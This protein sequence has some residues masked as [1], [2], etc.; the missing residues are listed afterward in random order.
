[1]LNAVLGQKRKHFRL[2]VGPIVMLSLPVEVISH[3]LDAVV[4]DRERKVTILPGEVVEAR[5]L[6]LRPD[7]CASFDVQHEVTDGHRLA[8]AYEKVDMI[9]YAAGMEER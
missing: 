9:S 1:M 2:E 5:A 3:G 8:K 7:G 4:A 6:V